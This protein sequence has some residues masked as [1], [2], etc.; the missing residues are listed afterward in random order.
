MVQK[1]ITYESTSPEEK[2]WY[3][4]FIG[5]GGKTFGYYQG[6]P[7]G[8]YLCDLTFNYTKQAIPDLNLIP[9]YTTNRNTSGLVPVT[10]DL[11]KSISQGAGYVDFQGHGSPLAWDTIWFDGSYPSDWC[12]GITVYNFLKV[13]NNEKLPIVVV[14]GCH[15]GLYN[16]SL[17]K[18]L[19]DKTGSQ[20]FTYGVP[21]PVCFS[22]SR[23]PGVR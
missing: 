7:D 11:Q 4:N 16:V 3:R 22:F 23:D 18:T 2:P 10:K 6:K 1:I 17:L 15:N 20:Y 13:S 5:I 12:G 14:G 19:R 21:L 9:V 8:E